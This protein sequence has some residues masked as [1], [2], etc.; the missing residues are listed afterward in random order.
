MIE[1]SSNIEILTLS[2]S[3]RDECLVDGVFDRDREDRFGRLDSQPQ[4]GASQACL[5][6]RRDERFV[7][8]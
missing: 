8:R 6:A 3:R 1:F 7:R 5:R 4:R 2:G